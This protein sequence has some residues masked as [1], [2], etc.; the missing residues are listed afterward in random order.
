MTSA[1]ILAASNAYGGRVSGNAIASAS[2]SNSG[3]VLTTGDH[4]SGIAAYATAAGNSGSHSPG[5]DMTSYVADNATAT[6]AIS[7]SGMVITG[8]QIDFSNSDW[9]TTTDFWKNGGSGASQ[10][11]GIIG[12][13][14]AYGYDRAIASTS[15]SNSGAVFTYGK[16]SPGI[17]G[18]SYAR[19]VGL[20]S[21]ASANTTI[22]NSNKIFTYGWKSDGIDAVAKALGDAA[23][24]A[25]VTNTATGT[26]ITSG[27]DT[28]GIFASSLA[29]AAG[30]AGS[31]ANATATTTIVNAGSIKTY[32]HED[33]V[34]IQGNATAVAFLGTAN[35]T[36][37]ATNSGLVATYGMAIVRPPLRSA[38]LL[39]A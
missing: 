35:A 23:A 14:I 25:S 36:S 16:E 2:V 8:F 4:S 11:P 28:Y 13:A 39:S 21:T 15:I 5:W 3:A 22:V 19:T 37:S 12:S 27:N 17:S 26:I 30:K 33:A 32:G 34:G 20:N 10:S 18:Y 9:M 29:G 31:A 6:V 24:V 38:P 7:N 1:G